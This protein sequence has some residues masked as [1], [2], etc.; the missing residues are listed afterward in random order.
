VALAAVL[1]EWSSG[2]DYAAR[3]ANLT[4]SGNGPRLNGNTFLMANGPAATVFDDNATDELQGGTGLDLFF[5]H[6]GH[7][8]PDDLLDLQSSEVVVDV[9]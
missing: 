7:R 3:V 2:R 6:L 8:H 4:G 1:A 9:E 5:A